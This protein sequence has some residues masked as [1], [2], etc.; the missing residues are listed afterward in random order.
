MAQLKVLLLRYVHR[1]SKPRTRW[2][3]IGGVA[4]AFVLSGAAPA[5]AVYVGWAVGQNGAIVHTTN[6]GTTWSAQS[7]EHAVTFDSVA[8][9]DFLHG[10]TVG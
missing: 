8:F 7:P 6:G 10:W 9:P 3:I 5:S 1:G 4:A 2:G